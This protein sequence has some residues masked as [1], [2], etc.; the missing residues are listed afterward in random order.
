MPTKPTAATF[1][2]VGTEISLILTALQ[3]FVDAAKREPSRLRFHYF[4]K[5]A[6]TNLDKWVKEQVCGREETRETIR[7]LNEQHIW[8]MEHLFEI[9]ERPFGGNF[10]NKL[11]KMMLFWQQNYS[12]GSRKASFKMLTFQNQRNDVCKHRNVFCAFSAQ[13]ND[14]DLAFK[15]FFVQELVRFVTSLDV[16]LISLVTFPISFQMLLR[17]PSYSL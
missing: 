7:K 13:F 12:I 1:V 10:S 17:I 5:M 14:P 11:L 9:A 4:V 15:A 8:R 16:V 3:L 6:E 2:K